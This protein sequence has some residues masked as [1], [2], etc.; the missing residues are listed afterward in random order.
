MESQENLWVYPERAFTPLQL[1]DKVLKFAGAGLVSRERFEREFS[2]TLELGPPRY[3]NNR[4]HYV[5]ETGKNWFFKAELVPPFDQLALGIAGEL[6]VELPPSKSFCLNRYKAIDYAL[7]Q[8]WEKRTDQLYEA[9]G[10]DG[11]HWGKR[12]SGH[13]SSVYLIGGPCVARIY[14]ASRV[15]TRK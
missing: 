14:I 15:M 9:R 12:L 11:T 5:S 10:I 13:D 8:G 4:P 2:V 1:L 6:I 7:S 3:G